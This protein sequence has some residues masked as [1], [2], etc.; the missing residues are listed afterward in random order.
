M[1]RKDLCEVVAFKQ[2]PKGW[3]GVSCGE[4]GG[5]KTPCKVKEG[6]DAGRGGEVGGGETKLEKWVGV[7]C[8]ALGS[9][10]RGLPFILDAA[11]GALTGLRKGGDRIYV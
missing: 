6:W 3:V 4:N 10:V 7:C 5:K 9:R 1:V 2:S 11:V 8:Q